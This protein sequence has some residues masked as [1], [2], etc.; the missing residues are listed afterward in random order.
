MC[1]IY[2]YIYIYLHMYVHTCNHPPPPAKRKTNDSPDIV[3]SSILRFE[4]HPHVVS[5]V[6]FGGSSLIC[7]IFSII[8]E[9]RKAH[10][11]NFKVPVSARHAFF[12]IWFCRDNQ[13]TFNLEKSNSFL[14]PLLFEIE[15][16]SKYEVAPCYCAVP[17]ACCFSLFI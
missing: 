17:F 16:Q 5:E 14:S 4:Y 12:L 1:Y 10:F 2:I 9:V 15:I 13:Q 7:A 11:S 8:R 6:S 3:S